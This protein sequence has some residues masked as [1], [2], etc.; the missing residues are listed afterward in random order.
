MIFKITFYK[1]RNHTTLYN[2]YEPINRFMQNF[3]QH[4]II[5]YIVKINLIYFKMINTSFERIEYQ[6]CYHLLIREFNNKLLF[7]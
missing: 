3:H 7:F 4:K 6:Q 2:I 1:F 5:N